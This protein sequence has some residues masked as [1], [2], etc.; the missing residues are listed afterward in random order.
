MRVIASET[1]RS[2]LDAPNDRATESAF[3]PKSAAPKLASAPIAPRDREQPHRV[4]VE[5]AL[6]EEE[7]HLGWRGRGS[8]ARLRLDGRDEVRELL[9]DGAPDDRGEE[10]VEVGDPLVDGDRDLDVASGARRR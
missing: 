9:A 5:G 3:W 7:R 2:A 1:P 6:A 4:V 10:P 8:P